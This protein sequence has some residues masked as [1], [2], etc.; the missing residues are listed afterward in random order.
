MAIL[1]QLLQKGE[2]VTKTK[3]ISQKLRLPGRCTIFLVC[4]KVSKAGFV[5]NVNSIFMSFIM[6]MSFIL[7]YGTSSQQKTYSLHYISVP[8]FYKL[9]YISTCLTVANKFYYYS[10]VSTVYRSSKF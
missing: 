9:N 1:S 8:L 10:N 2:F 3:E 4:E 6:V 7:K 5:I